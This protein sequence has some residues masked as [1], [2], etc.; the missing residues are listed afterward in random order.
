M[1]QPVCLFYL[2]TSAW[3]EA[4]AKKEKMIYVDVDQVI[5]RYQMKYYNGAIWMLV[6]NVWESLDNHTKEGYKTAILKARIGVIYQE[7]FNKLSK[8][9]KAIYKVPSPRMQIDTGTVIG[10][11]MMSHKIES[12]F[13]GIVFKNGY[14]KTDGKGFVKSD[15][16]PF[17]TC[18]IPKDYVE[19][20]EVNK[21]FLKW[22]N[23]ISEGN[24]DTIKKY[25]TLWSY[26]LSSE[27][28]GV[29]FYIWGKGGIGKSEI[30]QRI[31]EYIGRTNNKKIKSTQLFGKFAGKSDRFTLRNINDK[32]MLYMDEFVEE[33]GSEAHNTMKLY[34]N[35]NGYL[36]Y[37]NKGTNDTE[38]LN[39]HSWFAS[40][41]Q[42]PIF[43]KVDDALKERI[44]IGHFGTPDLKGKDLKSF[45]NGEYI[46]FLITKLVKAYTN[47]LDFKHSRNEKLMIEE[48][49]KEW[50]ASE[51]LKSPEEKWLLDNVMAVH[52]L[53]FSAIKKKYINE[54]MNKTNDTR[55]GFALKEAFFVRNE[56]KRPRVYT[57]QGEASIAEMKKLS[58]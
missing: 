34:Q 24:K 15:A 37:E 57:Y 50:L 19:T 23:A 20:K 36:E 1:Q 56:N 8:D 39:T 12:I 27:T 4:M 53:S 54:T 52:G 28:L 30:T 58:N 38:T 45:M 6:D 33:T 14:V 17:S 44:V 11:V 32:S 41:N 7:E 40:A 5:D 48:Y 51:S 42:V 13:K 10:Q 47:S 46:P 18:Q 9:D 26:A 55:M 22:L 2:D 35:E 16:I 43:K 31:A 21:P 3:K 25:M 49:Q 29:L